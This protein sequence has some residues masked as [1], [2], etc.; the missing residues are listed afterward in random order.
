M[1][2]QAD[3]L[4]RWFCHPDYYDDIRGDLEE[5]YADKRTSSS[6]LATDL[7]YTKEILLLFRL[8]LIR[9]S[10]FRDL[11]TS[12][13]MIKNNVKTAIRRIWNQKSF[14]VIKIGGLAI[15]I[16][17]F[18]LI[19]IYLQ[20]QLT[21][22]NF[23]AEKDRIYRV[24]VKYLKEG[25][26]GVDFPA[27]FA[28]VLVNDYPEVEQAGRFIESSW[29]NQ[30][31][32]A[33][34]IQNVFEEG[35][36]FVDPEFL[37]ILDLPVVAGNC[38]QSM[39]AP[40]TIII[41]KSK[42]SKYFPT[43]DP[44]GQM[45]IIN[46]NPQNPYKIVGVF[47]DFPSNSHLD[48][49]FM[50]SLSEVEFWAGEQS[51]WGANMYSIYTLLQEGTD[52]NSLNEKLSSI[53]TNYFLPS[54]IERDFA[55]P[56][57][58]ANNIAYELQPLQDIY[59]GPA[60]IRD[61]LKHGDKG[62]LWVFG[63][64]GV[65]ILVIA[66][67]NFINLSIARYSLSVK[68][69]SIRKV[70]GATKKQ[71]ISQFLT[72]SHLYSFFSLA[73]GC[74]LAQLA[75]PFLN[76][77]AGQSLVFPI[78]LSWGILL[79]FAATFALALLTGLYPSIYLSNLKTSSAGINAGKP[80]LF[81]QR[82]LIVFQFV[83]SVTLIIFSITAYQQMSFILNKDVGFDKEQLLVIQGTSVLSDK[84]SV[85][86]DKIQNL[87][88]GTSVSV[89]D[90]LP[91]QGSRR[92]ADSFWKD[93]QQKTVQGVNAQI[94]QVDPDYVKTLGINILN[95]RDFN[96]DLASDSSA[97]LISQ[98]LAEQLAVGKE[99]DQWIS[100]KE[101]TWKT[102][103]IIDDFHFE[104]FRN[105]ISP[106]ALVLGTGNSSMAVKLKNSNAKESIEAI[107]KSWIEFAPTT[108]FRYEFL[109]ENFAAMHKDISQS[110][111]LFNVFSLLAILIACLGLFG[112]TAFNADQRKKELGIRKVLG[113]NVSDILFL[114][115]KDII[116]LVSLAILFAIPIGWYLV[117]FWLQG[118]AYSIDINGLIFFSAASLTLV[119]ALFT[120]SSQC[121][122]VALANP[123]HSIQDGG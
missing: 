13:A 80:N 14:S 4:F 48:V 63:L 53:T 45:L 100:N 123:V 21:Y 59:L 40:N 95:G 91:M 93:G 82:S 67:I 6:K 73:I 68:E 28:K 114:M 10:L 3:Q 49:D 92:Y 60:E 37:D 23:Y 107:R 103:G 51:Y 72:E 111:K 77:L 8:S 18:M 87:S 46:D 30:I 35:F 98:S 97:I 86:K 99:L 31:R 116:I 108:P 83:V 41:S 79:F 26:N 115:S 120:I 66:G 32:P 74:L 15:G 27:P 113:A 117:T 16:A 71:L 78:Q 122:K 56:Q 70:L 81:F 88:A 121:I 85:F 9:P 76:Q 5:L 52:V 64:S 54:W 58:I 17:A 33:N 19:A 36:A 109:D 44:V 89:G 62:L 7:F 34:Q 61:D 20:H 57:D 65:L 118:F 43:Q 42:A 84:V 75:L 22:D 101:K 105:N 12:R 96:R 110:A 94:W 47:E 90:Y 55:N 2:K 69:I 104:S 11:F 106:M 29:L 119:I 50:I 1:K 112:L 39:Q 102:I 24:T 38:I 25:F